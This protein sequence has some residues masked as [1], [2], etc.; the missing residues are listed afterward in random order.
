[1][2][3]GTLY[4]SGGMQFSPD[5]GAGWRQ[6]VSAQLLSMGYEPLD[7][8]A[9]DVAY[10]ARNN[11]VYM[12]YDE[13]HFLQYK[14]N[15]RR[16]FIYTDIRLIRDNSDAVLAYYD[17]SFRRGAGSFAECQLAY[18][19][20][21]PLFIVSTFPVDEIPGWL[22]ALSTRYFLSFDQ[23]FEYL[24]SLPKGILKKDKYGNHGIDGKYLCS[25]CGNVFVKRAHAFVSKVSPLYCKPCVDMVATTY[26]Q[27]ADRYEFAVQFLEEQRKTHENGL[28]DSAIESFIHVS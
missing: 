1:M 18:D 4:L 24:E 3:H 10:T 19:L 11:P 6:Q 8:T 7:I 9:I 2:Y 28:S 13:D 27:Q 14:S 12:K 26:E 21:K 16:Q 25:M 17:E 20:E 22:K 5:L 23:F 15:I